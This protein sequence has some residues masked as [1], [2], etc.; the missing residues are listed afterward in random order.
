[1]MSDGDAIGDRAAWP[2][3]EL[4]NEVS[5]EAVHGGR[6]GVEGDVI[7]WT[8]GGAGSGSS[9]SSGGLRGGV[10]GGQNGTRSYSTRVGNNGR[11]GELHRSHVAARRTLADI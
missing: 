3:A 7:S 10:R 1:M 2:T 9:R 11:N 4:V 5:E 8:S 6:E